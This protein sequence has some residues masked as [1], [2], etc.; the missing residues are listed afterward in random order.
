MSLLSPNPPF[1]SDLGHLGSLCL[2]MPHLTPAGLSETWLLKH[3]GDVHWQQIAKQIGRPA[4]RIEDRDGRRVYAAF[5]QVRI[6]AARFAEAREGDC[7]VIRSTLWR[8]SRT[9]L[10][11]RHEL[12][13]DGRAMGTVSLLSAFIRR[14]GSSNHRVC[15]VEVPGLAALSLGAGPRPEPVEA[16]FAPGEAHG[17]FAFT[18]CPSEDF[19]GAGFLYFA[20]YLAIAERAAFALN[21]RRAGVFATQARTIA[22]HGNMDPGERI[23]VATLEAPFGPGR[24]LLRAHLR[25]VSDGTLL[26]QVRTEKGQIAV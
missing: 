26:A 10:A 6:E 24:W 15:R 14:D 12:N 22:Y 25:R 13:V 9:Q 17:R 11:S 16:P 2:G 19:N 21:P 3:L 4:A 5:R 1:A 8:A 7:L 20:S 23:E 18:P